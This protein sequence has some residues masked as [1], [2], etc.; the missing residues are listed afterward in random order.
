[1]IL[2]QIKLNLKQK[3]GQAGSNIRKTGTGF[4]RQT[5]NTQKYVD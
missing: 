2:E 1:M 4:S 3:A 5:Y